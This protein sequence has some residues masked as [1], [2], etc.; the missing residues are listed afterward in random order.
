[1]FYSI[2]DLKRYCQTC[3]AIAL[4]AGLLSCN[5]KQDSAAFYNIDSLI[6]IQIKY[7]T[8]AH[9]DLDKEAVVGS[10]RDKTVYT[11][12]DSA[13][14]ERE[15]ELFRQVHAINK[16]I[17]RDNYIVDDGL[18]DI[19]SN[20]TVKAFSCTKDLPVKYLRIFYQRSVREP[21]KIEALL[22]EKNVL[23][24]STRLLSMEFQQVN[25]KSI[26]TYYSISGGQKM[27]VGDS[28]TFLITGKIGID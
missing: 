15:L 19:A 23:Y 5:K 12:K 9:A 3:L 8:E 28:V 21:R 17:N 1:M 26:L 10:N 7:L 14:W 18:T 13:A 20:L 22:D 2:N 24:N 16:P 25:N 6:S 27:M 11:P 4:L